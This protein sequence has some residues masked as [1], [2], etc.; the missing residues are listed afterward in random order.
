[1]CCAGCR[2]IAAPSIVAT[3]GITTTGSISRSRTSIIPDQDQE[4]AAGIYERFHGIVLDEFYRVAFRKKIYRTIA[5]LQ[6]DLDG[7]VTAYNETRRHQDD[8]AMEKHPCKPS[9][10]RC[11]L[12][13]SN[14][15]RPRSAG[16]G[17]RASCQVKCILLHVRALA[18]L[19][20]CLQ[21]DRPPPPR[22]RAPSNPDNLFFRKTT[23]FR[24]LS[25]S[26]ATANFRLD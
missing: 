4:P 16:P 13:G 23:A 25:S 19:T 1:M 11:A 5:E 9:L 17:R 2:R 21:Q 8:S 24:A 12:R 18:S 14:C 26:W 10:T 15:R 20:P 22:P 3:P 6:N 7:W